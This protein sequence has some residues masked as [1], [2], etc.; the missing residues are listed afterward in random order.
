M[1]LAK[2]A[3]ITLLVLSGV[4][5]ADASAGPFLLPLST[6]DIDQ[7]LKAGSSCNVNDG[8]RVLLVGTKRNAMVNLDGDLMLVSRTNPGDALRQGGGYRGNHLRID[9]AVETSE[10]GEMRSAGMVSRP[11]Q[12]TIR[13]GKEQRSFAARWSCG[14]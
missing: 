1:K 14:A 11:A 4:A 2:Y 5:Y 9:I 12:V 6:S 7:S 10:S 13:R 3:T 8:D